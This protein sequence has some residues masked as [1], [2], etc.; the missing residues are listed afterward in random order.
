M[1]KWTVP[2]MS[3]IVVHIAKSDFLFSETETSG[4]SPKLINL[5][6]LT[7]ESFRNKRKR[8]HEGK[9]RPF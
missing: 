9:E 8:K 3:Y 7:R 5:V 4:I 1:P 2:I 6:C